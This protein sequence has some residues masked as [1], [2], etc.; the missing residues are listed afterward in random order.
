MT[1]EALLRG[2]MTEAARNAKSA[3][4]TVLGA[5]LLIEAA[6]GIAL[7]AAPL[8]VSRLLGLADDTGTIW[9]RFSGLVLLLLVIHMLIGHSMPAAAKLLSLAGFVART[10]LGVFL[11]ALW[12]RFAIAGVLWLAAAIVLATFYFRYFQAEVMNRP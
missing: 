3:Y 11:I 8:G 12:G 1:N 7:L 9:T 10:I 2:F 5:V 6:V 4:Q